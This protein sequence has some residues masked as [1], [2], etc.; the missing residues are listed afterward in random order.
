MSLYLFVS[1]YGPFMNITEN[2]SDEL[3]K[4]FRDTFGETFQGCNV[5]L[6]DYTSMPVTHNGVMETLEKWSQQ[7]DQIRQ[8]EPQSKFLCIN[9]GVNAGIP[10]RSLHFERYCFNSRCFEPGH[11]GTLCDAVAVYNDIENNAKLE[12]KF[13]IESIVDSVSPYNPFSKTNYD[14]GTYLC[15]YVYLRTLVELGN[16]FD[17]HNFFVHMP[18]N[19]ATS[20]REDFHFHCQTLYQFCI[21][22]ASVY[23]SN[24]V[25]GNP[26]AQLD[27]G[28]EEVQEEE[29]DQEQNQMQGHRRGHLL[30]RPVHYIASKQADSVVCKVSCNDLEVVTANG[31]SNDGCN[32]FWDQ[33]CE[34]FEDLNGSEAFELD[35]VVDNVDVGRFR[36]EVEQLMELN[37]IEEELELSDENNQQTFEKIRMFFEFKQ[38][39]N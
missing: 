25:F 31:G 8:S 11:E 38:A 28:H 22:Y 21:K 1:G 10:N 19:F 33:Q 36:V 14:P 3:G 6:A 34:M 4:M 5:K 17:T 27:D 29:H 12:C 18:D 35:V 26:E 16:D 37:T 13:D 32:F 15:N 39:E 20:R 24:L 23:H 7:I 2:P 30:W 9:I